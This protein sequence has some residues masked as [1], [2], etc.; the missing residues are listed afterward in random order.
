MDFL[1]SNIGQNDPVFAQVL[2]ANQLLLIS[3]RST[4]PMLEYNVAKERRVAESEEI[5]IRAFNFVVF[6]ISLRRY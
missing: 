4:D 6:A 1:Y 5:R 3:Y 2:V